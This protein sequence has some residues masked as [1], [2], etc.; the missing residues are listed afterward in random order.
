MLNESLSVAA[1]DISL[2]NVTR[3]VA[4][5]YGI[6]GT[7]S[8]LTSER[9]RN[10]RIVANDGRG[11]VLKV[12]NP[13]EDPLVA[14]FQTSAL[15]H[16]EKEAPSLPVPRVV[17]ALNGETLLHLS[18]DGGTPRPVRMT[19]FLP[20]VMMSTVIRT[21]RLRGRLGALLAHLDDA[22]SSFT[23]PAARHELAWDIRNA[24]RMAALIEHVNGEDRR[25]LAR[26]FLDNFERHAQPFFPTLRSQV[27]H[28]DLN[29]H[30]VLVH[31]DSPDTI[32]G[33]LDFGDMVDTYLVCDVAVGASYHLVD[34]REEPR[35]PWE[36]VVQ[37]VAAY[38]AVRPLTG[39]EIDLLYDLIA[40][41][42]VITVVITGW[43]A[44]RYPE[45]S[46]YI[47]RNNARSWQGLALLL[48]LPRAQAQARLHQACPM[49]RDSC[50]NH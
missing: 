43:R 41:R 26:H 21:D 13:A 16:I 32:V 45:N 47:L 42:F 37:F 28:N 49:E 7:A 48:E 22:L 1:E 36:R 25:A 30:N 40:A 6:D 20:G 2:E 14:D 31:P 24:S 46:T 17:H 33:V 11:Y 27:V 19:R 23:H 35:G 9:D 12:G 44:A 38:H 34:E 18:F 10:F 3:C 50:G 5:H 4:E 29:L 8:M 15:L 39:A